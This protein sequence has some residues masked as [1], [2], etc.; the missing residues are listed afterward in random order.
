VKHFVHRMVPRVRKIARGIARHLPS[1][2]DV[3][4]LVQAGMTGLVAALRTLDPTRTEHIELYLE[5]RVR[6]AIL[7]ELRALD[8]LSRAER[9][10][11]RALDAASRS[12]RGELGREPDAHE[13]AT[14]TGLTV[15]RVRDVRV[16]Q[17]T[18][19]L[20]DVDQPGIHATAVD[21]RAD[22]I[23]LISRRRDVER[24][25]HAIGGLPERL[26]TI[27]NLR[28]GD[29]LTLKQIGDVMHVTESRIC[30][31]HG[32]AVARLREAL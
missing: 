4:D 3:E 28:Y 9:K 8:P 29:D 15:E 25:T 2:V 7:D 11:A 20:E 5:R 32:E 22:V 19:V 18:A 13:L 31:M 17:H 12:L 27:I 26:R 6:G 16:R 23:D 1:S 30:Q 10:D 24:L 14:K 21:E